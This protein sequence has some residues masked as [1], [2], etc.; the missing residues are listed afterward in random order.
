MTILENNELHLWSAVLTLDEQQEIHYL[1]YLSEDEKYRADRFRTPQLRQRFIAARG[2]LR[3]LLGKYLSC[4]PSDIVFAY[5][6][7]GKPSLQGANSAR[8]NFNIAHSHDM[9]VYGFTIGRLVGVDIEKVDDHYKEAIAKRYFTPEENAKLSRLAE[10][11]RI[12]AFYCIWAYKEA[13]MKAIGKGLSYPIA[14]FSVFFDN[15]CH[16]FLENINW[17]LETFAVCEGYASAFAVEEGI[18]K[19]CYTEHHRFREK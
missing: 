14:Q 19:I 2:I 3:E 11:Q 16:L 6:E 7:H 1:T 13:L 15:K 4:P 12:Q 9:A 5:G 8:L 10:P 18:K 17:H